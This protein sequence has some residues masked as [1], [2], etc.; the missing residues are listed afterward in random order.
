LLGTD[1]RKSKDVLISAYDDAQGVTAAFN[2]NVLARINRELSGH[3]DLS[4]FR[5]VARWNEAKSRIEMHLESTAAQSAWIEALDLRVDFEA[6]ETI[7]TESSIKYDLP[8]VDRILTAAGFARV[9]TYTD[10]EAQLAV[11]LARAIS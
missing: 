5:H 10:A 7:H 11:H 1:L 9:Q 8:R 3:F 6:G 2:L 4:R